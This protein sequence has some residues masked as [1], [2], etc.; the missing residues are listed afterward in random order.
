MY[1]T[2]GNK[3]TPT[4]RKT[5]VFAYQTNLWRWARVVALKLYRKVH[6]IV[7]KIDTFRKIDNLVCLYIVKVVGA[8]H[9]FYY[10]ESPPNPDSWVLNS[11]LYI[12]LPLQANRSHAHV[13]FP[14]WGVRKNLIP[15]FDSMYEW[16]KLSFSFNLHLLWH[17]HV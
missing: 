6:L 7:Y 3:L 14:T 13:V 2:F 1:F 11:T 4:N 15:F 8:I 16:G 12:A 5:A 10:V 9:Y 17:F